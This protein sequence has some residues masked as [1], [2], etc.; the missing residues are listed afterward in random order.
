MGFAGKAQVENEGEMVIWGCRLLD[1][2]HTTRVGSERKLLGFYLWCGEPRHLHTPM[3]IRKQ[4]YLEVSK[5]EIIWRLKYINVPHVRW[6]VSGL[7]S[8]VITGL[9]REKNTV[10]WLKSTN[11]E[12]VQFIYKD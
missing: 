2:G 6:L 4:S 8:P 3:D 1:A 10:G 5:P 7:I 11:E 12:T 9:L